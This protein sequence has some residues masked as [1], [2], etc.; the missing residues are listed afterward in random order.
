MNLFL[1]LCSLWAVSLPALASAATLEPGRLRCEMLEDPL[2]I[3]TAKPR[4]SWALSSGERAQSQTAYQILVASTSQTLAQ[5]VGDLWDSG[6]V[7][8]NETL[9]IAYQGKPLASRQRAHWKVRSWNQTDAPSPWSKPAIFEIGLLTPD[10]WQARW[11]GQNQDKT[12]APPPLLRTE[13][14]IPGEVVRAR[15]YVCGLGYYELRLNGA[16]IGDHVLDPGYTRYDK[17]ALYAV[18]DVT[19]AVKNGKNALGVMLG[20]GW[21][22]VQTLAVWK[23]E[24]APW[25]SAP[26]LLLRLEADTADGR[27]HTVVSS[28]DW[29]TS[30]GPITFSSIYGGENYDA[31]LEQKGWDLPGFDDSAWKPAVEAAPP[32]GQLAAQMMPPIRI[33]RTLKPAKVTEPKPGVF[34]F[35]LGQN[36]AGFPRLTLAGP[37][38]TAVSMKCGERLAKD[39]TVDMALLSKYVDAVKKEQQFQTNIYTLKGEGTETWEPRF[40]YQGFQYVEVTGAPGKLTADNL[41]GIVLHT[42]VSRVG[43]FECSHPL[44][45]RI[46]EAT[47]WSYL[48]NLHSIPT[49]CPHREKNGWTGDAQLA[50]ELGLFNFD[51][52]A[53]YRKWL[54]DMADEHQPNSRMSVIIPNSGWGMTFRDYTPAWDA[55]LFEIPWT[56]YLLTGDRHMLETHY[57][58]FAEYLEWLSGKAKDFIL[59]GNLGDWVPFKTKTPE[60][61]TSTAYFFRDATIM[62]EAAAL[63]GKEEDKAKYQALAA[64]IKKA[65]NKQ[66]FDEKTGLYANGSQTAQSAA[67]YFGLAEPEHRGLILEK[68]L[69]DIQKNNG[70]IDTGILG[71]KYLPNVLTDTGHADVFYE[72]ATKTTNPS[73]GWWLEQGGTTLWE[74]WD[75]GMSRNHIMFGEIDAW[76]YKALAGI[77][78]DPAAPGFKHI[79]LRPH[80]VKG[81]R[82]AKARYQTPRGLIESSWEKKEDPDI[83][84]WE[85]TIPPNTTATV[86]LP[87]KESHLISESGQPLDQAKGVTLKQRLP[88]HAILHVESGRYLFEAR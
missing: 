53:F 70:H 17:R 1:L 6:K 49:D 38:G 5:D 56:V 22:N 87:A 3:D 29:K 75:G 33:M 57:G 60:N 23:F 65:Y 78:P 30:I 72:M 71:S 83:F 82:F 18:Y 13:F 48:G 10:D 12:Q 73:W 40:T 8:S 11:I 55:A 85:I 39:G 28:T 4:L 68:L 64:N 59:Q 7:T 58:K 43:E 19:A 14:S 26:K 42:D 86:H 51:G 25:R 80:P 52:T 46:E 44:L 35:D 47:R 21:Y 66:F 81:L 9:H 50:C 69:A 79:L 27:T 16:K 36:I 32:G 24:Q 2:G 34:V 76:F 67:L 31:R 84:K 61:L 74:Q 54:N 62:A 88:G 20:H 15:A 45:N 77:N 37:A 63:L 41:A